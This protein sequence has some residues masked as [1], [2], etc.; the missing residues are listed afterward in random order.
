[1][2]ADGKI[3][4]SAK[5]QDYLWNGIWISAAVDGWV[6]DVAFKDLTQG[7]IVSRSSQLTLQALQFHGHDAHAGITIAHSNDLLA[8]GIDFYARLVHPVTVKMMAAGN[9]FTDCRTH[10]DGRD[11]QN[12]TDAVIDFHGFFPYENLFEN[13]DGFYVCPGGDLSVMPHAGV[14]NV[15]WNIR[16]PK[17]MTCY[18]HAADSE[19][20]RSYDL[21]GTSSGTSQTMFEHFPQ[22]FY[23]GIQR[24]AGLPITVG[25]SDSDRSVPWMTVEGLNRAG[26]AIPSLYEAQKRHRIRPSN[27]TA[28]SIG[29]CSVPTLFRPITTDHCMGTSIGAGGGSP[30]SLS[31]AIS[32]YVHDMIY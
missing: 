13:L 27:P 6:R 28:G 24:K 9:V 31:G 19:F 26:I 11:A 20:A 29:F 12:A 25:G 23:V 17:C 16:A 5:E 21:V 32:I 10:Y 1:L 15:F 22:A 30:A 4:R 14:R 2:G 8:Q 7:V 3:V 18:T